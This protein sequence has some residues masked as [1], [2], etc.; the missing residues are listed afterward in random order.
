VAD[1]S[2]S[3]TERAADWHQK[4][5]CATSPASA[6]GRPSGSTTRC[7]RPRSPRLSP[8]YRN[9]PST[10]PAFPS[11]LRTS[12]LLRPTIDRCTE[13]GLKGWV[14]SRIKTEPNSKTPKSLGH[15]TWSSRLN[16]AG[17]AA[18][19]DTS[20]EDTP[21][22]KHSTKC[23]ESRAA[24]KWARP[25]TGPPPGIANAMALM[26]ASDPP[27]WWRPPLCS[28]K[29]V[30]CFRARRASECSWLSWL[31]I[32]LDEAPENRVSAL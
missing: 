4:L 12:D 21:S 15:E 19:L 8:G 9:R 24:H 23:R 28:K 26:P 13:N 5:P 6:G 1:V 29:C 2:A 16:I 30:D 17:S 32:A 7:R 25:R 3:S 18:W 31:Q 20:R 10:G 22:L 27:Y 11:A 14:L